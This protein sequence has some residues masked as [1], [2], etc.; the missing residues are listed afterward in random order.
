MIESVADIA[1]LD[2]PGPDTTITDADLADWIEQQQT[3][4]LPDDD[5]P[6]ESSR[7]SPTEDLADWSHF[8]CLVS[9]RAPRASNPCCQSGDETD[10]SAVG[11]AGGLAG[12]GLVAQ[13]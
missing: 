13:R 9:C 5:Y 6:Y 11:A 4:P 10:P 12:R 8:Y 1:E 7:T 3:L 2:Y